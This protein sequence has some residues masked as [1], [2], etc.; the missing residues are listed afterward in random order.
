MVHKVFN[1][2]T[3]MSRPS[4]TPRHRIL[5]ACD[6]VYFAD[7]KA[8]NYAGMVLLLLLPF[9]YILIFLVSK[10]ISSMNFEVLTPL[11]MWN[12]CLEIATLVFF[13]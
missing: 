1:K 11:E 7:I 6:K 4:Q 12:L 8:D 3:L 9:T 10:L 13:I 2:K 5:S